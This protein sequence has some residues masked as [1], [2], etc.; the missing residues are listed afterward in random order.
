MKEGDYIRER[1]K[2]RYNISLAKLIDTSDKDHWTIEVIIGHKVFERG[3]R[4]TFD[5][6]YIYYCYRKARS[7][8]SVLLALVV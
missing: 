1:V 7:D 8:D 6:E 3:E 5:S 2:G 4:I